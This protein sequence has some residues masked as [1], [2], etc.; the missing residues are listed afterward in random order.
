MTPDQKDTLLKVARVS[1]TAAV[2]G[3]SVQ[4]LTEQLTGIDYGGAF[5]TL[6]NKG[7]LRGCMG[8]FLPE[9]DMLATI[10]NAAVSAAGDPRFVAHPIK[11]NE[12]PEINIEISILSKPQQTDA[13]LSLELGRHGILIENPQGH[14]CFLPHVA[15]EF[16][17]SREEFLSRCCQD[18]AHLTPEA[19]KEP[20]TSVSLFTAEVL[21]EQ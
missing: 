17:W 12:L 18:K 21:S 6:R 4:K 13:P 14:G 8:T 15:T 5:V 10:Q 20:D 11:D 9:P 19:W 7:Q 1:L 16:G 2:R 3:Q